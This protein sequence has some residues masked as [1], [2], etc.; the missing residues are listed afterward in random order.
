MTHEV[1]PVYHQV[2]NETSEPKERDRASLALSGIFRLR[3]DTRKNLDEPLEID[4][5]GNARIYNFSSLSDLEC[6]PEVYKTSCQ[7]FFIRGV[8]STI[9]Y[10]DTL[11]TGLL[12]KTSRHKVEGRPSIENVGLQAYRPLCLTQ[13]MKRCNNVAQ[14]ID[15]GFPVYYF[16]LF[17]EPGASHVLVVRR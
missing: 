15:T 14:V 11:D 9:W 5:Q 6:H 12:H 10:G 16:R 8:P 1:T 4:G 3:Q 17:T 2:L 7:M 13:E